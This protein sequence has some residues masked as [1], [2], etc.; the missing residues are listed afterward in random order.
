MGRT[1]RS[2]PRI[3][4]RFFFFL[5]PGGNLL[6]VFYFWFCLVPL[7]FRF[8]LASLAWHLI[9]YSYCVFRTRDGDTGHQVFHL[10]S[11]VVPLGLVLGLN[12]RRH[13]RMTESLFCVSFL[14][15]CCSLKCLAT[16]KATPTNLKLNFECFPSTAD[17]TRSPM[18]DRPNRHNTCFWCRT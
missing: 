11:C 4:H 15:L 8:L 7:L 9:C 10:V 3:Q 1:R 6:L 17:T 18:T 2:S 12:P 16:H 5:V 13:S 14:P